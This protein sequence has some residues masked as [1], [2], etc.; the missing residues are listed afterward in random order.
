MLFIL[1][2]LNTNNI[3]TNKT[4]K[5]EVVRINGNIDATTQ[6]ITAFIEVKDE[7]LKE[8]QY[9]EAK[10]NAKDEPDAIEVDRNLLLDNNKM[11]V[12]KDSLLDVIEVKPVHFTDTKM[13]VK[14]IPNNTIIL[15]RQVP[16]AYAGM[17][18]TPYEEK[19]NTAKPAKN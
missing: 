12:L 10:L 2:N 11:F 14:G 3:D 5:G 19:K 1:E 16:G 13:V 9:L 8:G 6:T 18:V 15:K 4:Y 7:G 17:L